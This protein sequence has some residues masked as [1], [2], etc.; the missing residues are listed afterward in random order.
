[1]RSKPI[2]EPSS[3]TS[4]VA[5]G[6]VGLLTKTAVTAL[7]G[8]R[9]VGAEVGAVAVTAVRGSVRAAGEIGADVGRLAAGAAEGAIEAAD[10]IASAAGKAVG[11]LVSGTVEGVRDIMQTPG[12]RRLGAVKPLQKVRRAA[13]ERAEGVTS[14]QRK[15]LA[16]RPPRTQRMGIRPDRA[17]TG[18]TS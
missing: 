13:G 11:N 12:P 17:R 18:S 14:A 8:V 16:R 9:D 1:V 5:S 6:V 4:E 3:R 10:R 7:S 2:R 15:P